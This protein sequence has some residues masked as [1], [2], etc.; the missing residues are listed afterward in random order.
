MLGADYMTEYYFDIELGYR[1]GKISELNAFLEGKGKRPQIEPEKDKIV[2]IQYQESSWG[3]PVG[4][5]TILK[6]WESSE[7]E[8]I[9]QFIRNI[10]PKRKWDFVPV[11]Y[12]VYFDLY[13]L[14]KRAEQLKIASNWLFDEW[15]VYQEL[16][17]IN[18]R[19]ICW[20]MNDFKPRGSGLENFTK[21]KTQPGIYIPL[22]YSEKNYDKIIDYIKKEAEAFF[23][24]FSKLKTELPKFRKERG[25]FA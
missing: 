2:T 18:I 16:P 24:V 1:E 3:K 7:E 20:G 14:K 12:F 25:F 6:E 19:D 17:V 10:D 8:I 22:W 5:L 21:I 11:G 15:F 23:D 4:N 9:R 13:I